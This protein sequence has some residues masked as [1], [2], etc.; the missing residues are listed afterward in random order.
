VRDRTQGPACS[1]GAGAATAFRNYFVP[2]PM[3]PPPRPAWAPP[4]PTQGAGVQTGQTAGH[5]LDLL[6]GVAA[7]VGNVPP[8]RYFSV[9]GGYLLASAESLSRLD[10]ALARADP[11]ELRAALRVGVH[12][13][14]DVQRPV[15]PSPARQVARP[16]PSLH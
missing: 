8:G 13:D 6:A 16:R 5:Q 1:I 7:A 14:A 2:T 4:A 15:E 12:A 11:D 3:A 10:A 9:E